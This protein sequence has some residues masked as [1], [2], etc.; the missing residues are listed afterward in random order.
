M[1]I[2][3]GEEYAR[4]ILPQNFLGIDMAKLGLTLIL[5]A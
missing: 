4:F 3:N 5:I 2:R 1:K